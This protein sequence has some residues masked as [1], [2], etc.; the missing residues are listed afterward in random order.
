VE[1]RRLL[2]IDLLFAME[3]M[4]GL[5]DL[6]SEEKWGEWKTV[7]CVGAVWGLWGNLEGE[8]KG[9]EGK[10]R[11]KKLRRKNLWV[12]V[13]VLKIVDAKVMIGDRSF[14]QRGGVAQVK[15]GSLC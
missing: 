7:V 5:K 2:G 11:G 10:K 14:T 1:Q 15:A 6:P 3:V 12:G 4:T 9:K 13:V 8:M